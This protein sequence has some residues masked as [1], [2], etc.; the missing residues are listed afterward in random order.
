MPIGL[1]VLRN[2]P[3]IV[4]ESQKCRFRSET[5]VQCAIDADEATR[6]ARTMVENARRTRRELSKSRAE[7]DRAKAKIL[8][9]ETMPKLVADLKRSERKLFQAMNNIGNI[10]SSRV[11]VSRD[12]ADNVLCWPPTPL[13]AR[14]TVSPSPHHVVLSRLNGAVSAS[15]ISTGRRSYFLRGDCML[16]NNAL[17]RYGVDFLVARRGPDEAFVPVR[18]PTLIRESVLRRG[19]CQHVDFQ[20]SLYR[21]R[22]ESDDRGAKEDAETRDDLYLIATS[23]QPMCCLHVD[24]VLRRSDLP[25]RYV[26]QSPCFRREAGSRRDLHGLF[27]V[28]EFDKIEQFVICDDSEESAVRELNNCVRNSVDF[29][30]SLGISV[31]CVRVVSGHLSMAASE[32]IDVEAWFP[33]GNKKKG[34]SWREVVSASNCGDYQSRATNVRVE[35]KSNQTTTRKKKSARPYAHFVNATLVASQRTLCCILENYQTEKGVV[36]PDV[37]VPY[38]NG[39]RFLP[40]SP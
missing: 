40:F 17:L 8:A 25:L 20:E 12:E 9:R 33:A 27:R 5:S 34:G 32:K 14:S 24:D 35:R 1:D 11:P 37:L 6:A 23:E 10:L 22:N 4:M 21:V 26:A 15:A 2:D 28:H 38:M 29:Y 36:V 31:R 13:R 30:T 19:V 16:L 3:S 39:K 7:E 18:P